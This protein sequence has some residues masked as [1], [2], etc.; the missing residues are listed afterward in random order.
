MKHQDKSPHPVPKP[1]LPDVE[2]P[3]AKLLQAPLL[4][5]QLVY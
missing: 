1:E 3:Q 2:Q 4:P 5:W